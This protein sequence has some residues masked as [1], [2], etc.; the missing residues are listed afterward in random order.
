MDFS[1]YGAQY[2]EVECNIGCNR[3]KKQRDYTFIPTSLFCDCS[4]IGGFYLSNPLMSEQSRNR[5]VG[6]KV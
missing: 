1:V 2:I 5:L 4:L 3:G 6:T